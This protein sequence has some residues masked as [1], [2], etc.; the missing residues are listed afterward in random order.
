M[1]IIYMEGVAK[2]PKDE[3]AEVSFLMDSGV[4]YSLLPESVWRPI[5]L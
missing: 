1:G 2:G 3:E 4:S 5:G